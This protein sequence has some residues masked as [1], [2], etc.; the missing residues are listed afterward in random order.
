MSTLKVNTIQNASGGNASTVDN[1]QQGIAKAWVN[2]NGTTVTSS[3]DLTGVRDS[4]N[5]AG[6]TDNGTGDYTIT[7]TSD[8]VANA[9]YA[10]VGSASIS[11]A[12]LSVY[13]HAKSTGTFQQDPT[14]TVFRIV[15]SYSGSSGN[16]QDSSHVAVA[17]FGD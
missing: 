5:I 6:I 10:V 11:N 1:I 12:Y 15:T 8:A 14:S 4:F 2:F 7:M 17:V 13:I 16:V 9:N 3:N